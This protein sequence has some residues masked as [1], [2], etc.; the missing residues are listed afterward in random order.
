M[1]MAKEMIKEALPIKCLEAVI[2]GLYPFQLKPLIR[3]IK[4]QLVIIK[5]FKPT[6]TKIL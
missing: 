6:W 5:P 4:V 2:L 3:Q 1:D